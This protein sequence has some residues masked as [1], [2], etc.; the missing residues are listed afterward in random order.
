MTRE[1][2][3]NGIK[4][5]SIL[6]F[7]V[8]CERV[9]PNVINMEIDNNRKYMAT[10]FKTVKKQGRAI[11]SDHMTTILNLNLKLFASKPPKRHIFNFKDRTG[12]I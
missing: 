2:V 4:V 6:D 11:D 1:R 10:N 9:L 8:V 12:S 3:K 5:Q 7:Y